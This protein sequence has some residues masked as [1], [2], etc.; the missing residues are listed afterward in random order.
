MED[1]VK[2]IMVIRDPKI[3]KIVADDTRWKILSILRYRAMTPSQLAV[4]L[5][6]T[7]S[8]IMHHLRVL[9][10]KGLVTLVRTEVKGNM[11]EKWYKA[12]ARKFII[13]Y[14]LTEG[15]VPGSEET[16]K[17]TED[18]ARR[19]V[20]A[21]SAFGFEVGDEER[22]VELFRKFVSLRR[23]ALEKIAGMQKRKVDADY[24]AYWL[25]LNVLTYIILF[26]S[27]EFHNLLI[28][29]KRYLGGLDEFD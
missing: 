20:K 10:E 4:F 14:E 12:T 28:G 5:S 29:I 25:L 8:S 18:I 23:A 13:S 19:A 22:L 26:D 1:S 3:A 6:K 27:N 15:R 24:A 21:L 16:V 17:I 2:D 9:E 7:V 11:I